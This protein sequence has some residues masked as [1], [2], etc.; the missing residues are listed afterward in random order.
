MK[1][2]MLGTIALAISGS[3][4]ANTV[5]IGP[6]GPNTGSVFSVQGFAVTGDVMAGLLSVQVF[7][8]NGTNNSAFFAADCSAN[9]GEAHNAAGTGLWTLTETGNTDSLD[10]LPPNSHATSTWTLFNSSADANFAISRVVLNGNGAVVF[11]RAPFNDLQEGTPGSSYGIDFNVARTVDTGRTV[12]VNYDQR[13][14]IN[15]T[16]SVACN[17]ANFSAQNTG[18][19]GCGDIFGRITF[20]FTSGPAFIGTTVTPASFNF[21]Q[22]TDLVG[23]PEPVTV[24]LTAAGL[25]GLLVARKRLAR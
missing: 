22:D 16:P 3:A 9:C 15:G 13:T 21:F 20:T 11:D 19:T 23:S 24:A 4:S 10:G 7:F 25:L 1:F 2:L 8:A 14:L 17:G 12:T 6:D 5:V 18:V